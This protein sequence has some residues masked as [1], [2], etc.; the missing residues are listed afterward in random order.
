MIPMR[1]ACL[2]WWIATL[3]TS[4]DAVGERDWHLLVAQIA[5][6]LVAGVLW[7]SVDP[8]TDKFRPPRFGTRPL[9]LTLYVFTLL[10]GLA[11]FVPWQWPVPH[12]VPIRDA[13]LFTVVLLLVSRFLDA[14]RKRQVTP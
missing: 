5:Q 1:F 6:A 13:L 10:L 12:E 3:I 11:A 9:R 7:F 2:F 8:D 4:I 14:D